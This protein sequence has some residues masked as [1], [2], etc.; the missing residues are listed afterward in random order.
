MASAPVTTSPSTEIACQSCGAVL[1]VDASVRSTTCPYCASPSIIRRPPTPNRPSPTFLVGF[2]VNHE[3]ATQAVR[4][5]MSKS[6]AFA[7]SD[8][9]AAV[10]ELTHGIYLPA[11]LYGAV[12]RANYSAS[13]GENYTETETYTT[14]DSQGKSVRRTR[15]VTKTE[16]RPLSGQFQCYVVDVIV[17]AS[18]GV[19]N[20]AL[21]AIEPF[22]LRSLRAYSDS[23]VAGWLA[24]EPTRSQ[25]ECFR[26]AHDETIAMVERRLKSFMPGDSHRGLQFHANLDNEVIDLVLLP[27]WSYAVR[28]AEDQPPVQILVNGQ[29]GRVGGK[30]P[31][32]TTKIVFAVLSVLALVLIVAI[33][34]SVAS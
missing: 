24:E 28:Y 17:T 32:S 13:I 4:N 18:G 25:A 16:W 15:T 31:V 23:F 19:S 34:L 12:A 26:F 2:V 14:T 33:L 22:D 6:H 7:R 30:V 20:Q 10:P 21:E 5:W 27:V 11:Y 3:Q 8:F 1:T 9:K 29:T